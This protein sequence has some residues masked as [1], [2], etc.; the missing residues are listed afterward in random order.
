[1]RLRRLGWRYVYPL[2]RDGH[3]HHLRNRRKG[4]G[5]RQVRQ[6]SGY[7]IDR[8]FWELKPVRVASPTSKGTEIKLINVAKASLQELL[9]DYEDYLRTREHLQWELDSKEMSKMR[10]LGRQHNDSPFFMEIVKTRSPDALI[11]QQRANQYN[12]DAMQACG[13]PD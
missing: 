10:E 9:V 13:I 2:W 6:A 7:W 4:N 12:K 5:N 11:E 3:S 1:M 8:G